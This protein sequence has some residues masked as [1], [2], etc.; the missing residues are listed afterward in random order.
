MIDRLRHPWLRRSIWYAQGD[1]AH[2]KPAHARP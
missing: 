1:P 2:N